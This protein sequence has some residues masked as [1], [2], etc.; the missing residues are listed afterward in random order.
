MLKVL[1]LIWGFI[2]AVSSFAY[3][4][5]KFTVSGEAKFPKRKGEILVWLKTQQEFEKFEEPASP[6]RRLL[7]KPSPQELKAKK[8]TFRFVNVPKGI[9]MIS[10]IQDLNKNG[11]MDFSDYAFGRKVPAEPFGWSGPTLP[12]LWDD[13]KFEVDKDISDIEIR[14]SNP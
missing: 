8:V 7:I 1:M 10:C 11:K 14:I 2:F 6:A 3:A 4:Q 9:Y 5:E 12:G 13:V